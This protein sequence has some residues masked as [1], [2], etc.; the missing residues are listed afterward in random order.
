M[1]EA[2][3]VRVDSGHRTTTIHL[4]G[5]IDI[6]AGPDIRAAVAD[7]ILDKPSPAR[8]VVDLTDTTF[9]GSTGLGALVLGH[10]AARFVG[11]VLEVA[12]GPPN[13]MRVIERSGLE[14][15]LN[16]RRAPEPLVATG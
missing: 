1:G 7:A 6:A 10:H 4:G 9:L 15:F 11:A 8:L 14:R 5:E 13:V 16:V 12:S 3:S 2:Y